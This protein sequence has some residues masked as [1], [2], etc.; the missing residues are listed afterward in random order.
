[1]RSV[2]LGFLLS[3]IATQAHAYI[4]P[5][6]GAGALAV[7][8]GFIVAVGL[9]LFS[10]IWYPIKRIRKKRRPQAKKANGG[11]T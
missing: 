10:I 11:R 7:M 5:G 3:I 6:L 4:G 9:A 2:G 1:M 8:F